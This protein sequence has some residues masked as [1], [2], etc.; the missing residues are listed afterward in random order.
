MHS[1]RTFRA[2]RP[3]GKTHGTTK[4]TPKEEH[5]HIN[6]I[7]MKFSVQCGLT[8][9]I[10]DIAMKRADD[11][12]PTEKACTLIELRGILASRCAGKPMQWQLNIRIN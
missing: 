11:G 3:E 2:N 4:A 6:E 8:V 5:L 1:T 9:L 12:Q 10:A 7:A